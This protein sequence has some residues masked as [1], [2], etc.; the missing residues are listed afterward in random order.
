MM[1]AVG[2]AGP[3]LK[4]C[5]DCGLEI[6]RERLNT[7]RGTYILPIPRTC[8]AC[9][10][11]LTHRERQVDRHQTRIP[12]GYNALPVDHTEEPAR[13]L[14]LLQLGNQERVFARR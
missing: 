12:G 4:I 11:P 2:L 1:V 8:P 6:G 10:A 7:P 13:I 5:P 3:A 14:Q 9:D